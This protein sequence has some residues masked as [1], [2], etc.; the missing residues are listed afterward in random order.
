MANK[1]QREVVGLPA[2]TFLFTVDQLAY[3]IGIKEGTLR[4]TRLYYQGRSFG[5]RPR[6]TM[7]ASNIA[8]P[9]EKPDWR[10]TEA[11]F[12]RWMRYMGYRYY[13]KGALM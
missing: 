5:A 9:D 7:W 3:M 12:V 4:T 11:E 2:R 8:G 10:V 1:T 13:D 6:D